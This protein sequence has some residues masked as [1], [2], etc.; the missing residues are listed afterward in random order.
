MEP[1]DVT[2][3]LARTPGVLEAQL[4]QLPPEWIHRNDGPDT[5][6]AYDILGHL[7]HGEREDWLPRTRIILEH[8]PSRPFE[9]FDRE[10]MRAGPEVESPDIL[11]AR[12]RLM[13][14]ANLAE[15]TGLGL[16]PS[17]MDRRGTHPELGEV[18]LGQ[19][20]ATWVVHDLTHVAQV[21][22]V[23]ARRYREAVGPWRAYLPALDRAAEAE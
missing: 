11:L 14:T 23:L 15:L 8:G 16:R 1:S 17:D 6:S 3:M 7:V 18:S 2:A 5:W 10:A 9:S 20:L 12:F 21:G 19:L 13:R 4:A 22:E